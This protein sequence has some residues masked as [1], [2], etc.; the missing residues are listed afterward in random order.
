MTAVT[1][2]TAYTGRGT[3][4]FTVSTKAPLTYLSVR[5]ASWDSLGTTPCAVSCTSTD[6]R[7]ALPVTLFPS[8][9][10]CCT[11]VLV[12]YGEKSVTVT[13]TDLFLAGANSYNVSL[14][15]KAFNELSALEVGTIEP[16][17]WDFISA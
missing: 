5:V 17:S 2:A 3:S 4:S 7:V 6:Y 14:S 12:R 16:I 15:D 1:S 8:G 11:K 13:F 10:N 9:E